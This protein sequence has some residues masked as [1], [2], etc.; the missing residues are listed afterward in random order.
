MDTF[1]DLKQRAK[2]ADIMAIAERV[3]ML[4][5]VSTGENG[6]E[7]AAPCPLNC[8]SD[9][10]G[11]RVQPD[12][13]RW[14]CRRCTNGKWRDAIDLH[15]RLTHQKFADA[16][17]EL[18]SGYAIPLR[19]MHYVAESKPDP[20]D[21]PPSQEWQ[22]Q[23]FSLMAQFED[24]LWSEKGERARTW[25]TKRGLK[26]ETLKKF[27][28][29]Y[30]PRVLKL[31]ARKWGLSPE[32]PLI[33][34]SG[35]IIPTIIGNAVWKVNIRRP[36]KPNDD[37]PKYVLIRGSR[38]N[39]LFNA[40]RLTISNAP[41]GVAE[42]ELDALLLQQETDRACVELTAVTFGSCSAR[43]VY[44]AERLRSAP[45]RLIFYDQDGESDKGVEWLMETL[46]P[47]ERVTWNNLQA[48]DKD[49]TD[50]HQ[51]GGDLV[52]LVKGWLA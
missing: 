23:A 34:Q 43:S 35:I 52:K 42:G 48:G 44:W 21:A 25:L 29:G 38:P 30:N 11:F 40:D 2:R 28:V 20:R 9:R 32:Y 1:R 31:D 14:L 3:A 12:R 10:D 27:R 18:A 24:E 8:G 22:T 16:V 46:N 19:T 7:F 5:R 50:Y 37:A 26:R 15:Q 4:R 51:H 45:R 49:L 6:P 39:P 13:N 17:W 36:V 47:I 33:A 41:V